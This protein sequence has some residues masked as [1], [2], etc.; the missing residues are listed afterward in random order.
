VVMGINECRHHEE[1]V[2]A[3]THRRHRRNAALPNRD[4]RG[5]ER[6]PSARMGED[7]ASRYSQ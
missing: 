6:R 1:P 7:A 3:A 2:I 4:C 5:A